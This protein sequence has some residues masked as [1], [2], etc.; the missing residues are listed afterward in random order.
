[1]AITNN[2]NPN[3]ETIVTVIKL[4]KPFSHA[5]EPLQSTKVIE[6]CVE[7]TAIIIVIII[8]IKRLSPAN[9]KHTS[10]YS[11][12]THVTVSCRRAERF[13]TIPSIAKY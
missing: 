8:I 2:A 3:T 7:Q 1:V 4:I 9:N 5:L 12:A 13:H 10:F 6:L 11:V